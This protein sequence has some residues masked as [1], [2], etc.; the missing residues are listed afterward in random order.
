MS[1]AGIYISLGNTMTPAHHNQLSDLSLS[2]STQ[3]RRSSRRSLFIILSIL[4]GSSL[5]CILVASVVIGRLVFAVSSAENEITPVLNQFM[6]AMDKRN[7]DE[8]YQLFSGRA[9]QQTSI[10]DVNTLLNDVNYPL[11]EGYQS[12][13]IENTNLSS[14]VTTNADEAQGIV[15]TVNGQL[16]YKYEITGSFQAVLEKENGIWHI[17][18]IQ[19]TVPPE[20]LN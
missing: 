4:A 8:A 1:Y 18:V 3:N 20:K 7:A 11:F 10:D 9:Q 13:K 19:V 15:A 16:L 5:L 6:Q 17:F 2:D 14:R 12:I